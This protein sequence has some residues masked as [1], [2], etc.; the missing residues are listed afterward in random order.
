MLFDRYPQYRTRNAGRHFWAR[1]YYV[2]SIGNMNEETIRE[3]I[4]N[5]AETDKLEDEI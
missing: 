3:Y 1:G 2:V 5:Q 4:R